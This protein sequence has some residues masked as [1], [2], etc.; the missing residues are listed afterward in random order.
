VLSAA[1]A[2]ASA[3][4]ILVVST[5]K[6]ANLMAAGQAAGVVSAKV[7][8][9]TEGMVKSMF[10]TK[11]KSVLG[12][13]LVV[14]MFIGAAGLIYQTHAAGLPGARE[15]QPFAKQE[16][17]KSDDKQPPAQP[18][19]QPAKTDEARMVGNWFIM[20]EESGRKGEMWVITK[21][22][23]LMHA[24]NLG[25]RDRSNSYKIDAGKTPKQIDINEHVK[26]FSTGPAYGIYQL[27]G[28]ELRIC[29]PALG[30][31][32]PTEFAS[33]PGAA[34]VLILQRAASG[35]SPPKAKERQ[36]E[37]TDEEH[38]TG[39]W[40]IVND[41]SKWKRELWSIGKH[42]IVMRAN[43]GGFRTTSHFHRLDASKN[44]KQIDITVTVV[45]SVY[46]PD[47]PIEKNARIIGV[48]KGFYELDRG[49]LRLCLGEMGKDRPAAFPEKPKPGEVLVLRGGR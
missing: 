22:Q 26:G 37:K 9:L 40:V 4:P 41:D 17:K 3:P 43:V 31:E 7:A 19:Q 29:L 48:I 6:V 47:V 18:K 28:D 25:V 30:K 13:A 24:K 33:K 20:N 38:M 39:A 2:S 10:M 23:I 49:E 14:A 27:D 44:P 21:D 45:A 36:P 15:E 32:R 42:Q 35:A 16:Q 8:A 1:S 12:V 46:G 5:I 34:Q 11:I